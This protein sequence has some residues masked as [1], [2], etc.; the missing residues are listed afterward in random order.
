MIE[1]TKPRIFI[2]DDEPEVLATTLAM[3]ERHGFIAAGASNGLDA[4]QFVRKNI[5]DLIITDIIM[6]QMD[7]YKFF[8]ELKNSPLT[9]GI[10]I[11]VVSGRGQ[12]S[13]SFEALGVEG[14]LTKPFSSS[15][16]LKEVNRILG[17]D[18]ESE[19]D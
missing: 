6:P 3:F 9:S 19:T 10:P 8:K 4:I 18:K 1:K 14:F 2:V 11:L 17:L 15:N 12:M 5:P 7:G 16:L 13:S